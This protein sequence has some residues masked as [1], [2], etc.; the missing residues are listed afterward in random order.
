MQESLFQ[1][2]IKI[3]DPMVYTNI[4][5]IIRKYNEFGL[6]ENFNY[7]FNEDGSINW[8]VLV[9]KKYLYPNPTNKEKLEKKYNKK[10][11][12]LNVEEMDDKDLVIQ[13]GGLK[14]LSQIR[15]YSSV[16][17]RPIIATDIYAATVCQII[18]SPNY[19]SFNKEIIFESMACAHFNN[20]TGFGRQY[21]V[22]MAENRSFVR[23]VRGFLRINIVS[24]EELS[25]I[26]EEDNQI[27]NN[28]NLSSFS[29]VSILRNIMKD[30]VWSFEQIKK[31]LIKEG[32]KGAEDWNKEEDLPPNV[33]L[34]I[35]E[36][37]KNKNKKEKN[38]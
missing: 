23:N 7:S 33:I 17:Y 16:T 25:M 28:N 22:E 12:E 36:R 38:K 15:Q 24:F 10:Y 1:E 5:S 6:L 34:N 32:I 18:W 20:T 14:E 27:N 37:I 11:S 3:S 2:N 21:L 9:E 26:K 4:P 8:R 29:P 30:N 35:I 13:L 19:E 31:K